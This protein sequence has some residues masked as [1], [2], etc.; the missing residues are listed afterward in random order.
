M[1][2]SLNN[3][4]GTPQPEYKVDV[5]KLRQ[6]LAPPTPPP[7]LQAPQP[8]V[9]EEQ[10]QVV[11]EPPVVVEPQIAQAANIEGSIP[12]GGIPGGY[13]TLNPEVQQSLMGNASPV[14]RLTERLEDQGTA[15]VQN[16]INLQAEASDDTSR[17]AEFFPT[18]YSGDFVDNAI[19][20]INETDG[21]TQGLIESAG[22]NQAAVALQAA[23]NAPQQTRK[24]NDQYHPDSTKNPFGDWMNWLG[25]GATTE[26]FNLWKGE[27][28][29]AG[30][31]T[32]GAIMYGLGL[33]QNVPMGALADAKNAR[34]RV[35]SKLPNFVQD[36]LNFNPGSELFKSIDKLGIIAPT[37]RFLRDQGR[38]AQA[39]E[40]KLPPVLS[41]IVSAAGAI[42]YAV[43]AIPEFIGNAKLHNTDD[44]TKPLQLVQALRGK[45]YSATSDQS[46]RKKNNLPLGFGS[47]DKRVPWFID[48]GR[49]VGAGI[50]MFAVPIPGNQLVR[51]A[52]AVAKVTS[53]TRVAKATKAVAVTL[54]VLNDPLSPIFKQIGRLLPGR[55]AVPLLPSSAPRK[56]ADGTFVVP[57]TEPTVPPQRTIIP[58]PPSPDAPLGSQVYKDGYFELPARGKE[59]P[60]VFPAPGNSQAFDARESGRI[61]KLLEDGG[62]DPLS[63]PLPPRSLLSDRPVNGKRTP[64]NPDSITPAAI[65]PPETRLIELD[66][67]L[68]FSPGNTA[69]VTLPPTVLK[70]PALDINTLP[71]SSSVPLEELS[72]LEVLRE[73]NAIQPLVKDGTSLVSPAMVEKGEALAVIRESLEETRVKRVLRNLGQQDTTI[74]KG[75]TKSFTNPNPNPK[76]DVED[77]VSTLRDDVPDGFGERLAMAVDERR[78]QAINASLKVIKRDT[79][80][81][82]E[83][84]EHIETLVPVVPNKVFQGDVTLNEF[85]EQLSVPTPGMQLDVTGVKPKKRTLDQLGALARFIPG[86]DGLP[87]ATSARPFKTWQQLQDRLATLTDPI[88]RRIFDRYGASIPEEALR[89]E[90]FR[91][92]K[93]SAGLD[94]SPEV[95][96]LVI[97]P[98]EPEVKVVYDPSFITKRFEPTTQTKADVKEGKVVV[99]ALVRSNWKQELTATVK[100]TQESIGTPIVFDKITEAPVAAPGFTRYYHSTNAKNLPSIGRQGIEARGGSTFQRS[101]GLEGNQVFLHDDP[102]L[103]K[104]GNTLIA[105]DIPTGTV[106][107]ISAVKSGRDG[108]YINEGITPD[109]IKGVSFVGN[110]LERERFDSASTAFKR[111]RLEGLTQRI[112]AIQGQQAAPNVSIDKRALAYVQ[113]ELLPKTHHGK[114]PAVVEATQAVIDTV[115][116]VSDDA[117]LSQATELRQQSIQQ[118]L[119][120]STQNTL[121]LPDVGRKELPHDY[122]H[123]DPQ[124]PVAGVKKPAGKHIDPGTGVEINNYPTSTAEELSKTV[125]K[126]GLKAAKAQAKSMGLAYTDDIDLMRRITVFRNKMARARRGEGKALAATVNS[127]PDTFFA[128]RA[129]VIDTALIEDINS[130]TMGAGTSNPRVIAKLVDTN[131]VDAD[132]YATVNEMPRGQVVPGIRLE[133]NFQ[134]AKNQALSNVERNVMP[135]K[136]FN[137]N[138]TFVEVK[139]NVSNPLDAGVIA[140]DDVRDALRRSAEATLDIGDPIERKALQTF[141][142]EVKKGKG[143]LQQHVNDMQAILAQRNL[144]AETYSTNFQKSLGKELSTMGYDSVGLRNGDGSLSVELLQPSKVIGINVEDLPPSSVTEQAAARYN[145][146]SMVAL[147]NPESIDSAVNHEESATQLIARMSQ[148]NYKEAQEAQ[149]ALVASTNDALQAYTKLGDEAAT[150]ARKLALSNEA[151]A[152]Q[153]LDDLDRHLNKPSKNPCDM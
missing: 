2:N 138:G 117:H 47:T 141:L 105:V 71:P 11:E 77:V 54:D 44:R 135:G 25:I 134:T 58:P 80:F 70:L 27:F 125:D 24:G 130:I 38:D 7:P 10:P 13:P 18:L 127:Y 59:T 126:K 82:P 40:G 48:P 3:L 22:R 83:V 119:E 35:V 109:N 142:R 30:K 114:S 152:A 60:N 91:V 103:T 33:L 116:K 12:E 97:P 28:G 150:E 149:E 84:L 67:I 4:I 123:P 153:R 87:L 81:T 57:P 148:D 15:R 102:T 17:N 5:P 111:T 29:Q 113:K 41:N 140:T 96:A 94:G 88:Y 112:E 139:P 151:D 115:L 144:T 6:P 16:L 79:A 21:I 129:P 20:S 78:I 45:Q 66:E 143:T 136:E 137:D 118:S 61:A 89:G 65:K 42:N 19:N 31:N 76:V 68:A 69:P 101:V 121:A 128:P 55:K 53:A 74:E 32:G 8:Q 39:L 1:A 104:Y 145:A 131:L 64:L 23:A 95:Q 147:N 86:E 85:A 43:A 146:D 46:D 124:P 107:P 36:V 37:Q 63:S 49:I 90:G 106:T 133:S 52:A 132:I 9:V 34:D 108:F 75:A 14:S 73:G 100:A 110:M 50:D 122:V 51:G 99:Q 93:R 56:G 26:N 120:V 72:V 98:K 62:Y 92:V